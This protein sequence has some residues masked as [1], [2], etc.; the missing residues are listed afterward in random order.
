MDKIPL[1]VS[2]DEMTLRDYFAGQAL[3]G[4]FSNNHKNEL[5][6]L[7]IF[8]FVVYEDIAAHVYEMAEAM[9]RERSK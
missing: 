7:G 5:S 2:K 6:E 8:D 1:N 9:L 3:I 4:Y